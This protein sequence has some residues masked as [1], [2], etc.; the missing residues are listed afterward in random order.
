MFCVESKFLSKIFCTFR[1]LKR[2]EMVKIAFKFL[3]LQ[4]IAIF[5]TKYSKFWN[6]KNLLS[7]LRASE[8]FLN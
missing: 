6:F 2:S 5:Q 4:I 1:Q 3:F 8:A 7:L